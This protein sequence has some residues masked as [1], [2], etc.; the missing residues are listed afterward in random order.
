MAPAAYGDY[1]DIVLPVPILTADE[2]TKRMDRH[3]R[4]YIVR[5]E[6]D[7]AHLVLYG[8]THTKDSNDPQLAELREIVAQFKPTVIL[9]EGRLGLQVRWL[10][11]PLKKFG[12][13]GFVFALAKTLGIRIYTWEPPVDQEVAQVLKHHPREQVA[14][15]YIMRPYFSGLR[16]GRPKAPDAFAEDCRQKRTQWPGLE[17]TFAGVAEIDT[18]WKRDFAG[19][20]D[21]RDTSDEFGLPGYLHEVWK[22]SNAA[23]D[24]HFARVILDLLGKGQRVLAVCGSSHAVKLEPAIKGALAASP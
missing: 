15:F 13:S 22:S 19:K 7:R 3:A 12:E 20:P 9:V 1:G 18:V 24:E 14:L 23:R 8:A 16:H 11:D 2:Y 10:S 17:K 6:L 5:I 4:P 21:W